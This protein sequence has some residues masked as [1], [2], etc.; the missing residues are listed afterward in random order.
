[1]GGVGLLVWHRLLGWGGGGV[2]DEDD[3]CPRLVGELAVESLV[4]GFVAE[5][6]AA[7]MGMEDHRQ[8]V[9]RLDGPDD[10]DTN[11]AGR[12]AGDH[13]VVDIRWLQLDRDACLNSAQDFARVLG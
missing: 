4:C 3:D 6:P 12:P 2:V 1:Q 7:A 11:L 8:Y 5:D 9:G 13:A 10:T